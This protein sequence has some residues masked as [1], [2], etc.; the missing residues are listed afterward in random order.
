MVMMFYKLMF[1]WGICLWSGA[2]EAVVIKNPQPMFDC[3]TA[4]YDD[5][6]F[7]CADDDLAKLNEESNFWYQKLAK[8]WETY[9]KELPGFERDY[10]RQQQTMNVSRRMSCLRKDDQAKACLTEFYK[11]NIQSLKDALLGFSLMIACSGDEKGICDFTLAESLIA[12]GADING[13]IDYVPTKYCLISQSF[14]YLSGVPAYYMAIGNTKDSKALEYALTKGAKIGI[15]GK[16]SASELCRD[17][18]LK[19]MK[20]LLAHRVNIGSSFFPPILHKF[21]AAGIDSPEKVEIVK[22]FLEN[23]GEA[24][25]PTSD[26]R[27]SLIV[28]LDNQNMPAESAEYVWQAAEKLIAQGANVWQKDKSGRSVLD[29][30]EQNEVLRN[31]PFYE[32]F[33]SALLFGKATIHPGFDCAKAETEAEKLT[34]HDNELAQL[35]REV[36]DWYQKVVDYRR[37]NL[38]R[39]SGIGSEQSDRLQQAESYSQRAGCNSFHHDFRDCVKKSYQQNLQDLKNKMLVFSLI[40]ACSGENKC[41]FALTHQLIKEG[42][43]ITFLRKD[44]L[45]AYYDDWRQTEFYPAMEKFLRGINE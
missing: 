34:C 24:E 21:L 40:T 35:D 22:L 38:K 23:R 12:D 17:F 20:V 26:P 37:E 43:E 33:K 1:F 10:M 2:V 13:Y 32:S 45:G 44:K 29:Y 28:L 18:N 14:P 11:K 27:N 30:L 16:F 19:E 7:V 9:L 3:A 31:S 39:T 15:P 4:K 42:A 36:K 5:E 8:F 25:L 6:K 41:D